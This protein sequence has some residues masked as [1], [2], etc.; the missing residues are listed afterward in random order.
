MCDLIDNNKVNLVF[1]HCGVRTGHFGMGS[2]VRH[3]VDSFKVSN[4]YQVTL[5][6]TDCANS[7]TVSRKIEDGVEIIEVPSPENGLFLSPEHSMIQYTYT[8]R[9]FEI[10]L[11]Y[12][13]G[14]NRMAIWANTVDHVHLYQTIIDRLQATG[15]YVHHNFSWKV[16][17]KTSYE[18][19][20]EQWTL[21][22]SEFNPLAFAC[23]ASQQ[24]IAS[25]SDKVIT[26]THQAE[27]FFVDILGIPSQKV[28]TIYNGIPLRDFQQEIRLPDLKSKYGFAADVKIIICCGRLVEEKGV[29]YLLEAFKLVASRR[30][31]VHLLLVGDGNFSELLKMSGPFWSKITF[32]GEATADKV[33]ELYSLATLGVMPSTQEQ[34]SITSIEMRAN[35][36]PIIVSAVEGLDEIFEDGFDALKISALYDENHLIYF[37]IQEFAE[38]IETLLNDSHL[39]RQLTENAFEKGIRLFT[40]EKMYEQYD[41]ILEATFLDEIPNI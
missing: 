41:Q 18:Y 6:L 37:S 22:N 26:V 9:V 4:N 36:L 29:K 17:V 15:I 1:L 19:F 10:V 39:A 31:D 24:H 27:R 23:T 5:L 2:Y 7:K 8:Q 33:K 30:N 35:R 32:T 38:K 14:R 16:C 28:H 25:I 21:G 13:Y 40:A 3:L 11:P 34:C 12:L 20:A